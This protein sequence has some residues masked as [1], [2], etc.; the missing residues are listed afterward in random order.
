MENQELQRLFNLY[1]EK[2]ASPEEVKIL[3]EHFGINQDSELLHDLILQEIKRPVPED[4]I[5]SLQDHKVYER[6]ESALKARIDQENE[7]Q[8]KRFWQTSVFRAVASVAAVALLISGFILWSNSR[9]VKMMT[10][11]A[12]YGKQLQIQL[13]DSSIMW[14]SAGSTIVYPEQFKS[15]RR[16]V[17]LISGDVFFDVKHNAK[18]PFI[19]KAKDVDVTVLGTS[20][21]VNAFEKEKNATITVKTGKVGVVQPSQNQP[22]T[23]LLPGDRAIINHSSHHLDKVK[24]DTSD[25]AAWRSGSLIFENQLLGD[26][27]ATLDRTYNVKITIAN[28][29]LLKERVTMRLNHQPLDNIMT[30]ISFSNHFNY[31][32]INEQLIVIR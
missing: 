23:F 31:Q 5:I 14:L 3:L 12:A 17:E 9:P 15:D 25:I 8:H 20:F 11:S 27:M 2:K 28:P 6:V 7:S 13:P 16:L 30:A 21:E 32:K 1:L 19:I 24:A 10:V 4:N 22:A 18:K 29:E 26:V